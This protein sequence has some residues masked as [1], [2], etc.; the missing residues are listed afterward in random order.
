LSLAD[1]A[2]SVAA[3][4]GLIAE[5]QLIEEPRERY[6]N[7][8]FGSCSRDFETRDGRRVIVVALA[9]RHWTSLVDATDLRD[10]VTSLETRLGVDLRMEGARFAARTE[11]SRLIEPW[12]ASRTLAEVARIF[13]EKDVLWGPYQTFKE[14]LE[15]DERCSTRNPLFAEV[16][17]PGIGRTLRATS[18][19]IF[20]RGERSR[21]AP[22][23]TM[24]GDTKEVLTSWL[25]LSDAEVSS[26]AADRIVTVGEGVT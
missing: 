23:P 14:L 8:L 12:I 3:H 15:Q 7:Y 4:L 16:D 10:A 1:V 22:A 19:L 18:P 11:I 13:S 17:Q 2:L 20:G 9:P 26:L 6:G 5:A 24:G 25:G 21:P